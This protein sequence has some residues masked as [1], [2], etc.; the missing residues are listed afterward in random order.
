MCFR[1]LILKDKNST[2][3]IG[4]LKVRLY[5]VSPRD[6]EQKNIM[7]LFSSL[8]NRRQSYYQFAF[9]ASFFHRPLMHKT[10]LRSV[11]TISLVSFLSACQSLQLPSTAKQDKENN[12]TVGEVNSPTK[13]KRQ[14]ENIK[15]SLSNSDQ[16]EEVASV[17]SPD[18]IYKLQEDVLPK[19][20][21]D[22]IST[23]IAAEFNLRRGNLEEA[24][25]G[26]FQIAKA[27]E[28]KQAIERATD[29]AIALD[30]LPSLLQSSAYWLELDD[31]EPRAYELQY[32]ALIST[33]QADSASFLLQ[34][35]IDNKIPLEFL[36]REIDR[37]SRESEKANVI[38]YSLTLL[39]TSYRQH[40]NIL[41]GEAHLDFIR[42]DFEQAISKAE[43][44]KDKQ[45]SAETEVNIY[46][47]LAFSQRQ[48]GQ[49]DK[50][51]TTLD[52][53][54]NNH[55]DTPRLLTPLLNF[56]LEQ[57][58][59]RR[60]QTYF[61]RTKLDANS[62]MQ[63]AA[64]YIGQL[65]D[66][67]FIDE[68]LI[69]L[70]KVDYSSSTLADQFHFLHANALSLADRKTE[71]LTH[72]LKTQGPL[73]TN[74]SRQ[75]AIWMYDLNLPEQ[76]N[77]MLMQRIE[78]ENNLD[79]VLE[80]TS[81]HEEFNRLDLAD[82]LLS[83]ALQKYPQ[84]DNFRYKRALVTEQRGLWAETEAELR[85]L[86]EKNPQ[87]PQYMNALGYMMLHYPERINEAMPLIQS[88][89]EL[90]QDDPAIIDSL[91]WGYF[92][93]GKTQLAISH[94]ERAWEL[95]KDPEIGAHLGEA[96]WSSNPTRA[97]HV[98]E[99]SLLIDEK[100]KVLLETIERLNPNL[101]LANNYPN[102][103]L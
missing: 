16:E 61:N 101:T 82:Q 93:Q 20:S 46:L 70:Q 8:K 3:S 64:S 51:I 45:G 44:V 23:T 50:A 33:G 103:G 84:Q 10:L 26:Y 87:D 95:L 60:A 6:Q 77:Q 52:T 54:L 7:N 29:I 1:T 74:G 12:P 81:L 72:L 55:P 62:K 59:L 4:I 34:Q 86:I 78:G 39:P 99:Q 9:F 67:Q 14:N 94:L 13:S 28:D 49:Q 43:K 79:I 47:I 42:G 5:I 22:N 17:H 88:A 58:E 15:K 25:K 56:L 92:L 80:V 24:Y 37:N 35:A 2:P 71:G 48:L 102:G 19:A 100:H 83:F 96:L 11:L 97:T 68:A 40:I 69:Q 21:S 57:G 66:H 73:K 98:W 76:I 32:E 31:T 75:A 53:A 38:Y 63:L 91:G 89:Y 85:Y 41:M 18:T 65:I 30:S 27:T 90:T 36:N